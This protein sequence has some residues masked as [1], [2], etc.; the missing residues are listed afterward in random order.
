MATQYN[1]DEINRVV[2]ALPDALALSQAVQLLRKYK[3]Y[4]EDFSNGPDVAKLYVAAKTL[5]EKI[6]ADR[7]ARQAAESKT[8]S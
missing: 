3:N 6:K 1:F 2:R 5:A 8:Q 7:I 4:T